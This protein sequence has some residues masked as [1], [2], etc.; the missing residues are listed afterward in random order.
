V[1]GHVRAG[2]SEE[3]R[4][5]GRH[6]AFASATEKITWV[7]LPPV[8]KV[9]V[10]RGREREGAG[11]RGRRRGSVPNTSAGVHVYARANMRVRVCGA[12]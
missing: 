8:S 1:F 5:V 7:N 2:L 3:L 6:W 4:N 9:C 12:D 11:E 10:E